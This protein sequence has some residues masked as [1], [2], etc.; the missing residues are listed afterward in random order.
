M[1]TN[2]CSQASALT[3]Q[4]SGAVRARLAT[5]ALLALGLPLAGCG[6]DSKPSNTES[7][8]PAAVRWVGRVDATNPDAPQF[9]WSGSG[10]VAK[11]S[12][13]TISLKI[14]TQGTGDDIYLQPV[15]DGTPAPRVVAPFGDNTVVVGSN[16][17]GGDHVV[18]LYRENEGK[19][20]SSVFGGFVEGTLKS[21]PSAPERLIEIVGDSISAG[22]G[23][24]GE[25]QHPNSGAD[26]SGGCRFSTKTESAYQ[27]YGAMAARALHAE[28]S[29]VAASGW[30]VYRDNLGSKTNVL[31]LVYGNTLGVPTSP[32]W[33]FDPKPQVVVIN[34]GTND[35]A[36]G[37]LGQTE[38]Q[39][40]YSAF[41]ATVR[42]KNP[43]AWIFC[44]IGPLLYGTG[45]A[46]AQTYINAA[47]D[48]ATA[49]GDSK[50]QVLDVGQQDATKG[51][52]CD[53]HPSIAE[54]TRVSER[55]VTA[56]KTAVGW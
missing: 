33:G 26:P 56:I 46:S 2:L 39:G 4:L 21:P 9:S 25:E 20:G 13:K 27:T 17:S 51:T 45:L 22:Y 49:A 48:E 47:V 8:G 52:G 12:G 1:K 55:L 30:G 50:I 3:P 41:L 37:D 54:H 44:M 31:P 43:D 5:L 19:L 32:P 34:L 29:I 16:L 7:D 6:S 42:E 23:N 53:W 35:F 14:K 18:E 24:L 36:Q 28:W 10:L 40:A 38:F 11:V 15:I